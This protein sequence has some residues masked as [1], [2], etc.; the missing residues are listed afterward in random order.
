LYRILRRFWRI[1]RLGFP[2]AIS[3]RA[4]SRF[5]GHLSPYWSRLIRLLHSTYFNSKL[6]CGRLRFF[7]TDPTKLRF[8]LRSFQDDHPS[9]LHH[10]SGLSLV[11]RQDGA[12]RTLSFFVRSQ[13]RF[14]RYGIS[15][16]LWTR[17]DLNLHRTRSSVKRL[18]KLGYSSRHLKF[19]TP[20]AGF[21]PA[22]LSNS[23]GFPDQSHDQTRGHSGNYK[24]IIKLSKVL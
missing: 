14:L 22:K 23:S 17:Q 9:T 8:Q 2:P 24:I 19:R 10:T 5:S 13:P 7:I 15:T 1:P 6:H 12:Q 21:E 20:E 16:K 3:Q 4:I 11:L 18:P